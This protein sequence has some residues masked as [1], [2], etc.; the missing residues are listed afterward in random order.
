MR[1]DLRPNIKAEYEAEYIA[2]YEN[3]RLNIKLN[4]SSISTGS[5]NTHVIHITC[6]RYCYNLG[7][8]VPTFPV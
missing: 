4:M 7:L 1:L 6:S 5:P 8:I 2:E 3:I